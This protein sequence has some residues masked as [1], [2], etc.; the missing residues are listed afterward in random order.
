MATPGPIDSGKYRD[1]ERAL[2]CFHVIPVL[3]ALQISKNGSGSFAESIPV[4]RDKVRD[5]DS[6]GALRVPAAT[7]AKPVKHARRVIT[8]FVFPIETTV[9]PKSRE[10]SDDDANLC[11]LTGQMKP[12]GLSPVF[13]PECRLELNSRDKLAAPRSK[14][15][16]RAGDAVPQI[17]EAVRNASIASILRSLEG[18]PRILQVGICP[19]V[20]HIEEI[21]AERERD[22]LG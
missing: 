9:T 17:A 15:P 12:S 8:N 11:E 7:A 22:A 3:S 2:S 14:V 16:A 18:I 5:I 10:F 6:P 4:P 13:P 21:R 20:E 1:L 19:A